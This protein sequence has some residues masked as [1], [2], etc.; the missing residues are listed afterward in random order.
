MPCAITII[1][2]KDAHFAACLIIYICIWY[3]IATDFAYLCRFE[4]FAYLQTFY[5]TLFL[6]WLLTL[7][8]A[9]LKFCVKMSFAYTRYCT[10]QWVCMRKSKN[11]GFDTNPTT[12][13]LWTL[14]CLQNHFNRSKCSC[15]VTNKMISSWFL[16]TL[17]TCLLF[18]RIWHKTL[19]HAWKRK[20]FFKHCMT[21]YPY[22]VSKCWTK[23]FLERFA[24]FRNNFCSYLVKWIS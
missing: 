24:Q 12:E 15:A 16:F 10:N 9:R 1:Q 8:G 18:F 23:F 13:T 21:I 20:S 4:Y 14:F 3:Y 5:P 6:L 2:M 19:D 11:S 17:S 7:S 22:S